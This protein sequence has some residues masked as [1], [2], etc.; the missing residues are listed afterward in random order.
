MVI[1]GLSVVASLAFVLGLG[2][3]CVWAL[4]K[5][6]TGAIKGKQR[7]AVEV[8]QR[9]P[10]GPKTG[11]AVVRVGEKVMALSVGEG[12][13]RPLFELGEADRQHVIA[14]SPVALSHVSSAEASKAIAM[15]AP[16]PVH[17]D[18]VTAL[19]TR[20]GTAI[21]SKFGGML[22]QAMR[23]EP[24][25]VSAVPQ[26]PPSILPPSQLPPSQLPQSSRVSAEVPSFLTT[27]QESKE[28]RA[29]HSLLNISLNGAT[30][31]AA[32]ALLLSSLSAAGTLHAQ[33]ADSTKKPDPA[34]AMAADITKSV[35][36]NAAQI[37]IPKTADAPPIA[38]PK[39]ISAPVRPAPK[40]PKAATPSPPSTQLATGTTRASPGL[41]GGDER[42][43]VEEGDARGSPNVT[44][45][46]RP[47]SPS[48]TTTSRAW[49]GPPDDSKTSACS[50][51]STKNARPS[52]RSW[53]TAPSTLT[54]TSNSSRACASRASM[55]RLDWRAFNGDN[56]ATQSTRRS[57]GQTGF[58]QVVAASSASM[59]L[60]AR[61]SRCVLS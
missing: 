13:V 50:P 7:V 17:H 15:L 57:S 16:Q 18:A 22:N 44:T 34:A 58:A 47:C 26:S 53:T 37:V 41:I 54:L 51:G 12:G 61:S 21:G 14:T 1:A 23:S 43:R 33:A 6:G 20:I 5:W 10:L 39:G 35:L 4:K 60:P 24:S 25:H 42:G 36:E 56:H 59:S 32:L 27:P 9:V 30:R 28:A 55:T 48:R 19:G 11:L 3:L 49:R 40:A 2:A 45:I 8:V 29:F 52:S 31:I 46:L 38:A